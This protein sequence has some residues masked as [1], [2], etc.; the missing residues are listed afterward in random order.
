MD[1]HTKTYLINFIVGGLTVVAIGMAVENF[2]TKLG[3]IVWSIPYT[4]LPVIVMMWYE[5]YSNKEIGK[6]GLESSFA[7]GLAFV[8]LHAFY[9]SMIYFEKNNYGIFYST[10]IALL[11]W[12]IPAVIAY[13]YL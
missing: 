10:L 6:L 4:L 11:V 13:Y 8:F 12:S 1:I 9:K 5:G 7:V 3:S 2:S